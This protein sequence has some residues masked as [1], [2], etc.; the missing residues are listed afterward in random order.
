MDWEI[1]IEV[2]EPFIPFIDQGWLVDLAVSVLKQKGLKPPVELGL[3][4]IGDEKIRELN[5][6]YLGRDAITD[7]LAFSLKE[8]HD[9]VPPPDNVLHLGEVIIC[10][11]QAVRQAEEYGHSVKKELALLVIHGLL[12]LLGY[13]EGE[14]IKKEEERLLEKFFP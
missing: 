10:Y 4:F 1:N 14:E 8:G 3:V 2:E 7:V 12:H 13:K 6:K 11:P 9:F 5:L